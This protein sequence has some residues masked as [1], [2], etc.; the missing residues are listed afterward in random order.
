MLMRYHPDPAIDEAVHDE[1]QESERLDLAAGYPPRR[2]RCDCGAEHAR[3]HYL[4]IGAH[5]CL[6]CGYVGTGGQLVAPDGDPRV[7]GV[8]S[9]CEQDVYLTLGGD[10]SASCAQGC[11]TL[12]A[13]FMRPLMGPTTMP[14]WW[15][16]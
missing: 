7:V 6:S 13:T 8:C 15:T 16:R 4:T 10:G 9:T 2:W 12:P 14:P 5:R 1:A 11:T 3:G